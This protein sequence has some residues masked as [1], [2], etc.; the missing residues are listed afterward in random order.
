MQSQHQEELAA[1]AARVEAAEEAARMA[2]S[3]RNRYAADWRAAWLPEVGTTA[4][5]LFPELLGAGVPAGL[6]IS[7]D[8]FP[9]LA[10]L[11]AAVSPLPDLRRK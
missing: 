5:L 3:E 9:S 8:P 2:I 1:M 6:R 10:F 4:G 11:T 7:H